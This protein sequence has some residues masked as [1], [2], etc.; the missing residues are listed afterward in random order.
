MSR[1]KIRTL[2][3]SDDLEWV[4]KYRNSAYDPI[5]IEDDDSDDENGGEPMIVEISFPPNEGQS[6]TAAATLLPVKPNFEWEMVEKERAVP[7]IQSARPAYDDIDAFLKPPDEL[8]LEAWIEL[9]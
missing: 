4:S 8:D 5:D 2:Y 7:A 9:I 3:L 1:P 6:L